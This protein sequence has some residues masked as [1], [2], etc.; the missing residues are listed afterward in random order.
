MTHV[1][2]TNKEIIDACYRHL[3]SNKQIGER[4]GYEYHFYKPANTKYGP[5]QWLWD[6][7]WHMIVWSH[8]NVENAIKD[9]QSLLNFQ[10]DN[11]FIPEMIFWGQ[12]SKLAKFM[13]RFFGYSNE[14]YTDITQMPMLAYSVRAIWN[15]TKN[16]DL[17][18]DFIPKLVRYFEWWE[19]ERDPDGDKLISIIHPWESGIDASPL[20][21]PA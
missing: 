19:K 16:V 10:Q 8:R 1:Y 5:S 3:E 2:K 17:L 21:D 6:S 13:D 7:G 9:L 15:A 18:K 11:G 14:K 4:W 20:Y 12:R